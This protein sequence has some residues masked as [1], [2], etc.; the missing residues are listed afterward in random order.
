MLR[1][2]THPLSGVVLLSYVTLIGLYFLGELNESIPG[3]KWHCLVLPGPQ[4]WCQGK[5]SGLQW[6]CQGIFS[7]LH[8]CQGTFQASRDDVREHFQASDDEGSITPCLFL[9]LMSR[10]MCKA[11]NIRICPR[12]LNRRKGLLWVSSLSISSVGEEHSLSASHSL[13][14]RPQRESSHKVQFPMLKFLRPKSS[15]HYSDNR[16]A[17][18]KFVFTVC[19]LIVIIMNK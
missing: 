7:G 6:W 15:E 14:S 13:C 11:D 18:Q 9:S 2:S 4:W 16:A 17:Q 1:H 19:F 12:S 10:R 3:W 8:W 5:I